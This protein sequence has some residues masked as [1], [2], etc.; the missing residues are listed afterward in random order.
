M[1]RIAGYLFLLNVFV[2]KGTG[3]EAEVAAAGKGEAAEDE[4]DDAE[5]D[6]EAENVS[7]KVVNCADGIFG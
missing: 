5:K 4:R 2:K 3:I 6:K 7:E 1:K